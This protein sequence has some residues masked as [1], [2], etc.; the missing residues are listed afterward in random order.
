M[1]AEGEHHHG[2][3]HG[4]DVTYIARRLHQGDASHLPVV[5]QHHGGQQQPGVEGEQV[6]VGQDPA[7]RRGGGGGGCRERKISLNCQTQSKHQ[8]V[9]NVSLFIS[10]LKCLGV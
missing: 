10:T 7:E 1:H 5:T 2:Q 3:Q 6:G 8:S 4:G 9:I